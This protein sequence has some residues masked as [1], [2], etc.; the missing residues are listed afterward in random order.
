MCGFTGIWNFDGKPVDPGLLLEM[1]TSIRHRGPDDEGYVMINSNL[2]KAYHHSGKETIRDIRSVATDILSCE[3]ANVGIGFR[4]LSIIDLSA[5]AHQPMCDETSRYWII[6]NGEIYN[7]IEI[8]Q[9]LKGAGYN[10]LSQ[11]DT[12]VVLKAYIHWGRECLT[13]FNGMWAFVIVDTVE[14]KLFGARDRFGV[15][16]FYYYYEKG[17]RFVFASE[18]K[19]ILKII[20]P[21]ADMGSIYELFTSSYMDHSDHTFFRDIVQLRPSHFMEIRNG[22]MDL[23][24]Y[25]ILESDEYKSSFDTAREQFFE[26]LSDSVRIRMRSDVPLGFALSGGVDSSSVIGLARN[27]DP[28]YDIHAFSLVYPG[29]NVDESVYI[30]KVIDKISVNNSSISPSHNELL[31]TLDSFI[32]HQEEPNN[33]SSYWGEFM[34]RDLIKKSGITVSLEGQGADEIITGYPYFIDPYLSD[35]LAGLKFKSYFREAAAFKYLRNNNITTNIKDLLFPQKFSESHLTRSLPEYISSELFPQKAS[36]KDPVPGYYKQSRLN[37]SLFH[38]LTVS[39]VPA[40]L[41]RADKSSM[42]FSVECRFPFLDYRIVE[43]A[44]S[45]PGNFKLNNGTTKYILRESVKGLIPDEVYKRRD[46]IGFATP[47]SEWFRTSLRPWIKDTINSAAF[48]QNPVFNHKK[49]RTTFDENFSA[50]PDYRWWAI[51][52]IHFWQQKFGVSFR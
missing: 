34:L 47:Q 19:A 42:A 37:K 21:V 17:K 29:R 35:L 40:Q 23:G 16:P 20:E 52:M 4:R 49:L 27:I 39:S 24:R 50:I 36:D 31:S 11:S 5:A 3:P 9:E 48:I 26:T 15:K 51:M 43:L 22:Q 33:G 41:V 32:W 14:N 44:F 18:I 30:K 8:R 2:R 28:A 10:F 12:E 45:M 6:L 38:S 7:Y 13:K 25:Y 46:K 1:N